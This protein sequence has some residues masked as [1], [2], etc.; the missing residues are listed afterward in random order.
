MR[1]FTDAAGAVVKKAKKQPLPK[2]VGK[3]VEKKPLLD[4]FTRFW[5]KDK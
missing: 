5:E 3:P 1:Q 2:F 4:I